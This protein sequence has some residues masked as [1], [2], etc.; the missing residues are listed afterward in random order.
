MK[1]R[2]LIITQAVDIDDPVLGFFHSWIKAF[3]KECSSL[4]VICLKEGK[5][6]LPSHVQV[7]S[8]GKEQGFSRIQ[9][10]LRFFSFIFRF[11]KEYDQVFVHMNKEY[12][13]LAGIFWWMFR[14]PMALWYNHSY[15]DVFTR[16]AVFFSQFVC[17]TS[18]SAYTAKFD[19][20]IRM[21]VGVDTNL[22]SL[23]SSSEYSTKNTLR[24]LSVGRLSSV[25]HVH[26]MIEVA[27]ILRARDVSFSFDIIGTPID[28]EEDLV[29]EKRLKDMVQTYDLSSCVHFLGAISNKELP[30][31]YQK[32]DMFL[33]FTPAGSMDK[34]IF[35][36]M[37]SGTAIV[38]AN[39]SLQTL[40]PESCHDAVIS[41]EDC[42]FEMI[43]DILMRKYALSL[44][45][46]QQIGLSLRDTVVKEHGL[47]LLVHRVISS[48]S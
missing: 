43:V 28:R 39:T 47:G 44:E 26:T 36:A 15:G 18:P 46:R 4:H 23:K 29:Y 12:A 7:H 8:L 14:K 22:F 16:L 37:S 20:A 48:F 31:Y 34:T 42:T 30:L 24:L 21:P 3:S 38:V 1:K 11:R 25:K 9:Y 5:H 2:M 45:E 27:A 32:V 13:V 35:E 10:V 19:K 33:N 6:D 41:L 17:Y 40:L